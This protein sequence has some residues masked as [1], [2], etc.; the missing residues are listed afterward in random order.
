MGRVFQDPFSMSRNGGLED[1]SLVEKYVMSEEEYDRRQGTLRH[2]IRQKRAADP[3]FQLGGRG[4]G[5]PTNESSEAVPGPE[6][7]QHIAVGNR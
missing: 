1:V 4:T 7:V 3:N 5:P 2:W 6:S